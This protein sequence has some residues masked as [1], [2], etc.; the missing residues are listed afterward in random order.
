MEFEEVLSLVANV[1][2]PV[3]LCLILLRYILDTIGEKLDKLD[4]SLNHLT[5][6]ISGIESVSRTDENR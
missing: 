5:K 1:G 4:E 3:A 6:V 2:F